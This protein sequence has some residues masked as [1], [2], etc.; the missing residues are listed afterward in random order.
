MPKRLSRETSPYLRQHED[1]ARAIAAADRRSIREHGVAETKFINEVR[2][3]ETQ[4]IMAILNSP[5]GGHTPRHCG[6]SGL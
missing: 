6:R 3:R 2:H 4:R 5:A 1:G